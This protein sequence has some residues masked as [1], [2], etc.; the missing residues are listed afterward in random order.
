MV[1]EAMVVPSDSEAVRALRTAPDAVYRRV[2]LSDAPQTAARAGRASAEGASTSVAAVRYGAAESVWRVQAGEPGYLVTTDAYYPG[3][4]A[5]V[6]GVRTPVY[7]ANIAFR[8]IEIAPGTH[9]V[10]YRYEP[11]WL[12]LAVTLGG[13][14]ALVIA[15]GLAWSWAT[16]GRRRGAG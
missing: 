5:Y 16:D 7:R 13:L 9:R 10:V 3:W 1:S 14:S 8:A 11:A 4:H 12:S 2:V 15:S 6:D